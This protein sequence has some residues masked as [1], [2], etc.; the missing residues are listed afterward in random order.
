MA[1]LTVY[2]PGTGQ[3]SDRLIDEGQ[4]ALASQTGIKVLL[5]WA[6]AKGSLDG[7]TDSWST[8]ERTG[9]QPLVRYNA[10]GLPTMTLDVLLTD[11][12]GVHGRVDYELHQIRRLGQ[13]E[14]LITI[15]G[16]SVGE[17]GPWRMT[18][19]SIDI[20][21]RSEGNRDVEKARVQMSFTAAVDVSLTTT[22]AAPVPSKTGPLTGGVKKPPTVKAPT[23]AAQYY[24]VRSGDSLWAI[25]TKYYGDPSRWPKIADANRLKNPSLIRPGQRLTIPPK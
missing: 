18:G 22:S 14:Q 23:P 25:A 7:L 4:V 19:L 5:P 8:V 11:R 2:V 12:S 15:A 20:E 24:T 13:G 9:R 17:E 21:Q 16:L 10:A 1:D 3:S 6:P